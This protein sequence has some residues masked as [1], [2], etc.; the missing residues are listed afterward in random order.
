[1][2]SRFT[3]AVAYDRIAFFLRLTNIPLCIH[4]M[5]FLPIHM[6]MDIYYNEHRK[7]WSAII[8]FSC[9]PS[10]EESLKYTGGGGSIL[11]SWPPFFQC[12]LENNT[13]SISQTAW[14][15]PGLQVLSDLGALDDIRVSSLY[16]QAPCHIQS[17]FMGTSQSIFPCYTMA[18]SSIQGIWGHRQDM[19]A[20]PQ[21]SCL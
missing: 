21:C 7:C 19:D 15:P 2:S 11:G 17:S 8:F 18:V 4:T 3:H 5:V 14:I 10:I 9:F 12:D 1:M 6:S 13:E 20:T 16:L